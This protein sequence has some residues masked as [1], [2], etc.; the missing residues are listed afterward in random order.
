MQV[1][2]ISLNKYSN[3]VERKIEQ[4]IGSLKMHTFVGETFCD[5]L[6]KNDV[7]S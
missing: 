7:I 2:K 6:I 5:Y 4:K 1:I 3:G